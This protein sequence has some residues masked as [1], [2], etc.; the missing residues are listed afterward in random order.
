VTADPEYWERAMPRVVRE[1][2][3]QGLPAAPTDEQM[4]ELAR[5]IFAPTNESAA[6]GSTPDAA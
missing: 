1:R 6:S 2:A 4:A 3:E 5:I